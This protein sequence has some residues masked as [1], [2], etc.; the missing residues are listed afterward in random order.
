MLFVWDMEE[1]ALHVT[2]HSTLLRRYILTIVGMILI[3]CSLLMGMIYHSLSRNLIH[4]A[5][6][7]IQSQVQTQIDRSDE[8]FAAW[9][10]TCMRISADQAIRPYNLTGN[11]YESVE[12]LQ[13]LKIYGS[14][15]SDS[16][17]IM[18]FLNG[19]EKLYGQQGI[20][21]LE[22]LLRYSGE[23]STELH[24]RYLEMLEDCHSLVI[25]PP[26]MYALADNGKSKLFACYP[27][28]IEGNT[29]GTLVCQIDAHQFFDG[30]FGSL[31]NASVSAV[32]LTDTDGN[33]LYAQGDGDWENPLQDDGIFSIQSDGQ[34]A[35]L[36]SFSSSR[37]GWR[38]S[39]VMP[40]GKLTPLLKNT[41][42]MGMTQIILLLLVVWLICGI[43]I[44]Y[45]FWLPLH[46]M[47][48]RHV[49]NVDRNHSQSKNELEILNHFIESLQNEN[50][51]QMRHADQEA[52]RQRLLYALLNETGDLPKDY[53][54]Q[55]KS[56]GIDLP[57]PVFHALALSAAGIDSALCTQL[58]EASSAIPCVYAVDM[59][60]KNM[61][62]F[63]YSAS[64]DQ[65]NALRDGILRCM[66]TILGDAF[67]AGLSGPCHRIEELRRGFSE[68]ILSLENARAQ[69]TKLAAYMDLKEIRE[70]WENDLDCTLRTLQA[71]LQ[72]SNQEIIQNMLMELQH[73]LNAL[74]QNPQLPAYARHIIFYRIS[75][76]A[77]ECDLPDAHQHL[78]LL[79]N[80]EGE[81][82]FFEALRTLCAS[83]SECFESQSVL[84]SDLTYRR[85][86]DFLDAHYCDQNMSLMMLAN[87]FNMS[88]PYMSRFFLEHSGTNFV[89]Y[90]S[91]K[92]MQ[93]ACELLRT[94]DEPVREIVEKVG[95]SN[96][97]SFTRKF[98]EL[99]DVTP[100][101]FR[102]KR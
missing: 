45:R 50:K 99:Y 18:I 89:D 25:T 40:H 36:I 26:D 67:F 62:A 39:A 49:H 56:V 3:P 86:I 59:A 15:L 28:Y 102:S 92:R 55:L 17:N 90:L 70:D 87:Q 48:Q 81:A 37:S 60:Y 38:L 96:V 77:R 61:I 2:K 93:R 22:T 43:L 5:E 66:E 4:E 76:I 73:I 100:G 21:H 72:H 31:S 8:F 24:D 35:S 54:Q 94:T 16:E 20:I 91:Q 83:L 98:S 52:Q 34:P 64:E 78:E 80:A 47:T 12:A 33:I 6:Q 7:M 97:S 9:I 74:R 63:V 95:Y 11:G 84:S 82:A 46:Q 68:A 23:K 10:N 53:P 71:G 51:Q 88:I 41:R 69:G 14:Q 79:M 85:I 1:L 101:R 30:L 44:A 32:R 29:I 75:A 27:W 13:R 19:S 58:M 42:L 57:G 65:E